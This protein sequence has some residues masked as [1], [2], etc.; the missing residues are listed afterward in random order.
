VLT[1]TKVFPAL[2]A[3]AGARDCWELRFPVRCR[4]VRC[5]ITQTEGALGAFTAKLYCSK[6]PCEGLSGSSGSGNPEG[7][8][9]ASPQAY[10]VGPDIEGL[11]GEGGFELE[12]G[13]VFE[14]MDGDSVCTREGFIYVEIDSGGSGINV[15]DVSFKCDMSSGG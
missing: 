14:N 13:Y 1:W 4:I 2:Q 3:A 12:Y 10:Q 9:E 15:F 8:F 6:R 11:N 5:N 7:G